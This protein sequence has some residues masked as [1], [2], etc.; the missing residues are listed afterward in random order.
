MSAIV[1]G[2]KYFYT[3]FV[4]ASSALPTCVYNRSAERDAVLTFGGSR[5]LLKAFIAYMREFL[6]RQVIWHSSICKIVYVQF[7][8]Y[9]MALFQ[10]ANF[11]C[12]WQRKVL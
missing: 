8:K 10:F 5:G 6:G 2:M 7:D 3:N 1:A 11:E 9:D 4:H 12:L